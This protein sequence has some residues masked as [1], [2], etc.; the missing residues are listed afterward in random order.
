MYIKE[1]G[2]VYISVL[3]PFF[4]SISFFF[5]VS[6]SVSLSHSETL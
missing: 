4:L 6:V 2:L 1:L 5:P 3:Q